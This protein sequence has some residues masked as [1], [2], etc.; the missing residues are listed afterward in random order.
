M[1]LD[2]WVTTMGRKH[3]V[4]TLVPGYNDAYNGFNFNG[5]GKGQVL[6]TVPRGWT[7]T[8]RCENS[9][10]SRL[11][12]CAVVRGAGES[13]PAFPGATT[14]SLA[15]RRSASFT[16]AAEAL[17]TYRLVCLVAHHEQAGEWDVLE[18]AAAGRPAVLLL[19]A[20]PE[21]VQ[22]LTAPT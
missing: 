5:Y 1:S 12:S 6:V 14:T 16:F 20:P 3:A 10:S 9:R 8:V 17:G 13:T 15:R 22:G 4:I 19:R 7:I 21:G 11:H 18:V 2:R